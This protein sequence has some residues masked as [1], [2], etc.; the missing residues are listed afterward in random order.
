M[1]NQYCSAQ[2]L[3]PYNLVFGQLLHSETNVADIL[4]NDNYKKEE[5]SNTLA[6]NTSVFNTL[7]SNNTSAS[8]TLASN[9]SVSNILVFNTSAI[10]KTDDN[11]KLY[12][13]LSDI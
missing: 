3:I 10:L 4:I 1:N 11:N 2:K 6:T 12:D 13:D 8:N 5:L 7:A 9:T